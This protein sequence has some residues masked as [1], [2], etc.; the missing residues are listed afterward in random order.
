[1]FKHECITLDNGLRVFLFQNNK[2][3]RTIATIITLAGSY[4]NKFTYDGK[5]YVQ[6][7]G[8]AHFLEHYLIEKSIYGNVLKLFS[9][10]Y[11]DT[12]GITSFDTTK[13]F[14]ST[15]HDFEKNFIKLLNVVNNPSFDKDKIDDVK[16]PIIEEINR[17]NDNPYKKYH[18]AILKSLSYV[19]VF[20]MGLGKKEDIKGLTIDDIKLF[21]DA[22]YQPSNQIIVISGHFN[23]NRVLD[24]I[25]NEYNKL[26]KKYKK[27]I[28]EDYSEPAKVMKKKATVVDKLEPLVTVNYKIDTSEFTPA[29]KNRL[30]YYVSYISTINFDNSST[31]YNKLIDNKLTYEK[32]F[33]SHYFMEDQKTLVIEIEVVTDKHEEVEKYIKDVFNN[34][35]FDEELFKSFK[36]AMI[37][38]NINHSENIHAVSRNFLGNYFDIGLEFVDDIDFIKSLNF[39]ECKEYINRLDLSNVSVVE[40]KKGE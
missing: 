28:K 11:I 15:V 17:S 22:F 38:D 1:M 7:Y 30:D 32:I 35:Y 36:N 18:T 8:I 3:N 39:D 37:I 40:L 25:N 2:V 33:K 21:H 19:K 9:D 10:D 26:N 13:F 29:E 20:N 34:L 23:K 24:I 4:N 5:E 16:N 31:I 14:I 6:P 12:N 27:T